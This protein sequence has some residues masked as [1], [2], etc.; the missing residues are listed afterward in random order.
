MLVEIK[1]SEL[2]NIYSNNSNGSTPVK[3]YGIGKGLMTAW[4]V[5]NPEGGDI[6]TGVD[7]S[8]RQLV[9]P[10]TSSPEVRKQPPRNKRQLPLV[11]L[12]VSYQF[13]SP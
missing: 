5:V 4:R 6:P 7:F 12:L 10:Q 13:L 1:V 2:T 8:N 11:S 9:S 3:K